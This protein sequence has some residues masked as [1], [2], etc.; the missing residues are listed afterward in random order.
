MSA[1]MDSSFYKN[2][3]I[4]HA[5]QADKDRNALNSSASQYTGNEGYQ[6]SLNQGKIGAEEAAKGAQAQAS[7]AYRNTGMTK[8]QASAMAGQQNAI[9]YL[10][11][12]SD[13]QN[14]AYQA[15]M[16]NVSVQKGKLDS[17]TG[18]MKSFSDPY[19]GQRQAE[20]GFTKDLVGAGLT[21]AGSAVA[22]LSDHNLKENVV[23]VS[24]SAASDTTL[25]NYKR[26][27]KKV[28]YHGKNGIKQ[29]KY[30]FKEEK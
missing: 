17:S 7:T 20:A 5:V 1:N 11:S 22:A 14:K 24:S 10:N 16:D 19:G 2:A 21:A 15:G 9:A 3:A 29:L 26:V 27:S 6:N 8:S 13:Q 28:K 18:S 25:D 23:N 4:V 30:E 12:L